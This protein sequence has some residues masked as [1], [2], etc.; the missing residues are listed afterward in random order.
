MLAQLAGLLAELAGAAAA[1][2]LE[3]AAADQTAAAA[4]AA[5]V[6]ADLMRQKT[7]LQCGEKA[8][9]IRIYFDKGK[10]LMPRLVERAQQFGTSN[11]LI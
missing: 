10:G 8:M 1:A 6:L 2:E 3:P 9:T 7:R 5:H 11:A 4:A